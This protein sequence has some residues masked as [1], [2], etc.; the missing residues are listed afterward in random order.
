MKIKFAPI[1]LRLTFLTTKILIEISECLSSDLQ[2]NQD[3]VI[4]FFFSDFPYSTVQ[5]LSYIKKKSFQQC[6]LTCKFT[7]FHVALLVSE[8][9]MCLQSIILGNYVRGDKSIYPVKFK[10]NSY[11]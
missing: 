8:L 11:H 1:W 9:Y 10:G 4:F 6:S 3:I 5:H 2:E 7:A